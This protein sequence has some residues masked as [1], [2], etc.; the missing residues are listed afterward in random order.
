MN[1]R[2]LQTIKAT[3]VG[4]LVLGVCLPPSAQAIPP[5]QFDVESNNRVFTGSEGFVLVPGSS[6]TVNNGT[7]ARNCVIQF[8]AEASVSLLGEGVLVGLA[9]GG[10]GVSASACSSAGGPEFF[11]IRSGFQE[12]HTAVFVR[13]IPSGTST[14]KACFRVFD[15]G[16]D[17]GAIAFLDDRTLTV[18]CRT[19]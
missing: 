7:I 4:A 2:L 3:A 17:R 11:H 14:I 5:N 13:N 6:V 12:T 8:S 18:E 15:V 9:I 19:Q 1:I 16:P 10:S